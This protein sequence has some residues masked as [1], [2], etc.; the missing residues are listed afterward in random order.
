MG[1]RALLS[2]LSLTHVS[3]TNGLLTFPILQPDSNIWQNVITQ[4]ITFSQD[5]SRFQL[6]SMAADITAEV[7]HDCQVWH[8]QF[9][10]LKAI[11]FI[12][13]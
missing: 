12:T 1:M 6:S 8:Y 4:P 3:H 11:L 2:S 13:L 5:I 10:C 9:F 7:S